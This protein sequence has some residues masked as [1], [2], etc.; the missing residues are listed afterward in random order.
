MPIRRSEASRGPLELW[1]PIAGWR[2]LRDLHIR[3][4][5]RG[6]EGLL[7][8]PCANRRHAVGL[9]EIN[10]ASLIT[11][12]VQHGRGKANLLIVFFYECAV[13]GTRLITQLHLMRR[14][15]KSDHCI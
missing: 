12:A 15:V 14:A 10:G 13:R 7:R 6:T 5:A 3:V 2:D 8:E 1:Q 11:L 9:E 4:D